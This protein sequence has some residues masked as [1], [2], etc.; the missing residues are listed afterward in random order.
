MPGAPNDAQLFD[1]YRKNKNSAGSG[2]ASPRYYTA[3]KLTIFVN[4]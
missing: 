2:G 1:L 4:K 3:G